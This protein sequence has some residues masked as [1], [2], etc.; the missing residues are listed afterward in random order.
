MSKIELTISPDYVPNWTIVDAI[1][2]LFQNALDQQAQVEGNT[3][4]WDYDEATETFS[5]SNKNSKLTAQ[6][7]L[8]GSTSKASDSNTIGQFGEG[9]KIATLVLLRNHKTVTFY[10]YGAREVW[11]PRFVKSRRFNTNVLTFFVDKVY[12]WGTVPDN[13][14]TIKVE[15]ITTAEYNND[16]VPSNLHLQNA[17]I[18]EMTEYGE[19][20]DIPGKVF[21]NGLFIC[22]YEPYV[23]GYN[24]KPEH[25]KLDRDRKL[26]SDF[27]LKW[28]ASKLWAA[29][30]SSHILEL[31]MDDAADVEYVKHQSW[32]GGY[33]NKCDEALKLF[34]VTYGKNT[35]PVTTQEEINAVPKGYQAVVVGSTYRHMILNSTSYVVPTPDDEE[36]DTPL[37]KLAS[38]YVR[39]YDSLTFELGAEFEDIMKELEEVLNEKI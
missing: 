10:N 34:H 33:A 11:T 16:I 19:A 3:A 26:V 5:I 30:D 13:D 38:W 1:R 6:S 2:E 21:V 35:V 4:A 12:M 23:H 28:L 18:L 36:E 22:K 14:L 29:T 24:F 8:F 37:K 32:K 7:L 27:D 9:Y 20:L 17:K 39:A 15:G 25:V 31:V